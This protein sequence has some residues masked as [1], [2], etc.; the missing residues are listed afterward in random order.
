MGGLEEWGAGVVPV[1]G[2]GDDAVVHVWRR[3]GRVEGDELFSRG[4]D[5]RVG[6]RPFFHEA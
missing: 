5:A 3:E 6:G 2:R 4:V 1:L